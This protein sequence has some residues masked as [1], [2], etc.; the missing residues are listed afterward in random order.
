[1][2][3]EVVN[4]WEMDGWDHWAEILDRAYVHRAEDKQLGDWWKKALEHRSGGFDR[5]LEPA[6][7]SPTKKALLGVREARGE[8]FIHEL[9]Q[10]KPGK[11]GAYLNAIEREW[12]PVATK[13]GLT[14][15]GAFDNIFRDTEA[16]TIWACQDT[17][18]FVR[19]GAAARQDREI[20]AWRERA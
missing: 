20:L 7:Y 3:P 13:Y 19:F 9:S 4:L 14:L 11:V 12:L 18:S 8:I 2:W 16:V 6:T 15:I 17:A 1:N 10:V 5:I